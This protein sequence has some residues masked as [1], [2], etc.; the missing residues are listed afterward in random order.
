MVIQLQDSFGSCLP[1]L[2][3]IHRL[4]KLE[5]SP[6]LDVF[7]AFGHKHLTFFCPAV[8]VYNLHFV[9][10][11]AVYTGFIVIVLCRAFSYHKRNFH[12]A[13]IFKGQ[14]SEIIIEHIHFLCVV[15]RQVK[16]V[17]HYVKKG[18]IILNTQFYVVFGIFYISCKQTEISGNHF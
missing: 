6:F 11:I 8:L 12:A 4:I 16:G 2:P 18:L 15:K 13:Y 17:S 10:Y 5:H 3:V 1:L 7:I 9:V 14:F